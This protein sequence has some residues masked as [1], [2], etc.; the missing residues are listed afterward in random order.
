MVAEAR[1][2]MRRGAPR[3]DSYG[4][5]I[6]VE[7]RRDRAFGLD[8]GCLVGTNGQGGDTGLLALCK[9]VHP[10]LREG[11]EQVIFVNGMRTRPAPFMENMR[12]V[13]ESADGCVVHGIYNGSRGGGRDVIRGYND[14]LR[15]RQNP[16]VVQLARTFERAMVRGHALHVIAHSQGAAV[17]AEALRLASNSVAGRFPPHVV[18]KGLASF[19]IETHGAAGCRFIDGPRYVHY[20]NTEDPVPH[21]SGLAP[22]LC[23]SHLHHPG[24]GAVMRYFT[25]VEPSHRDPTLFEHWE[26]LVHSM[27]IYAKH[28]E[29]FDV[30]YARG[31]SKLSKRELLA[32]LRWAPVRAVVD[33][34]M[35]PASCLSLCRHIGRRL[36]G[37]SPADRGRAPGATLSAGR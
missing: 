36:R 7:L 26:R 12:A 18:E 2:K 8:D 16:A 35:L 11:A 28:R 27:A 10:A 34:A 5:H 1:A 13:A 14:H 30:A 24:R 20:I 17:T 6:P 37:Q 15:A 31:S 29:P 22:G 23:L 33:L 4:P 21:F 3:P 19:R 32:R 25:Y 9:P